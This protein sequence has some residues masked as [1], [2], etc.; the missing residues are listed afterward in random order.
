[1]ISCRGA[2]PSAVYKDL[3]GRDRPLESSRRRSPARSR[4]L[5][6]GSSSLTSTL[7]V[8]SR[9][10]WSF[11]RTGVALEGEKGGVGGFA[12][13]REEAVDSLHSGPDCEE[14]GVRSVG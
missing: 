11:S 14:G 13:A 9:F 4:S 5:A 3:N 2:V 7:P 1:M 6:V 10:S 12:A 8:K